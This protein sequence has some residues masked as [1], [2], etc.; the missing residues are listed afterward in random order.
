M[1]VGYLAPAEVAQNCW[2]KWRDSTIQLPCLTH[3]QVK[4]IGIQ[5]KNKEHVQLT[6]IAANRST[7]QMMQDEH[8]LSANPQEMAE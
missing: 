3:R 4:T 6:E 7:V 5:K 2:K 1:F 8:Q